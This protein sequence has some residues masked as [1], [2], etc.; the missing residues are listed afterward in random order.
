MQWQ[1]TSAKQTTMIRCFFSKFYFNFIRTLKSNDQSKMNSPQVAT[2]WRNCSCNDNWVSLFSRNR[3]YKTSSKGLLQNKHFINLNAYRI[4]YIWIT[5]SIYYVMY[6]LKCNF[7]LLKQQYKIFLWIF[8]QIF[9]L[10]I[11]NSPL[12]WPSVWCTKGTALK[13]YRLVVF[14]NGSGWTVEIT[15][16]GGQYNGKKCSTLTR[17][18]EMCLLYLSLSKWEA[19]RSKWIELNLWKYI[20]SIFLLNEPEMNSNNWCDP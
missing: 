17:L 9:H 6:G 4:R 16:H 18:V 19:E 1:R 5:A 2:G 7:T 15:N 3:N 14:A 13:S 10:Q 11:Q 12:S 20:I 8:L